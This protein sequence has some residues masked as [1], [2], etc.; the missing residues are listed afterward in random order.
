MENNE[1]YINDIPLYKTQLLDK[2][3]Y[4]Q[5]ETKRDTSSEL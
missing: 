1:I 3:S 4:S 2:L 5:H